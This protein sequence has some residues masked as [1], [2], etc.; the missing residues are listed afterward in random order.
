MY[1]LKFNMAGLISFPLKSSEL[2]FS[3]QQ[4]TAGVTAALPTLQTKTKSSI[5][6]RQTK[7]VINQSSALTSL[8]HN[9]KEFAVQHISPERGRAAQEK[10]YRVWG[11]KLK[12]ILYIPIVL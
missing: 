5:S 10:K 2:S 6:E 7:K 11:L 3:Q 8:N 9:S 12:D 1:L 4:V